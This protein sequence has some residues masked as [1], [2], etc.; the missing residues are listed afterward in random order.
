MAPAVGQGR[1]NPSAYFR[2][3]V[4]INSP[5]M[6]S[7]KYKYG[8]AS[9]YWWAAFRKWRRYA[10]LWLINPLTSSGLMALNA[11]DSAS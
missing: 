11:S 2:Q 9:S 4:P 8:M 3:R 10:P 7:S 5:A 6:D 1:V